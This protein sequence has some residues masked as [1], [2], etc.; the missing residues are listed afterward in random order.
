[1]DRYAIDP[2]LVTLPSDGDP[3]PERWLDALRGWLEAVSE[4]PEYCW[5]HFLPCTLN[6][7]EAKRYPDFLSLR[8]LIDRCDAELDAGWVSRHLSAFF[9]DPD[10]AITAQCSIKA[11]LSEREPAIVPSQFVARNEA[12]AAGLIDD[13]LVLGCECDWNRS[14]TAIVS[15]PFDQAVSKV[16]INASIAMTEPP[17]ACPSGASAAI[18]AEFPF[19]FTPDGLTSVLEPRRIFSIGARAIR[20]DILRRAGSRAQHELVIGAGFLASLWDSSIVSDATASVKLLR[21]GA[22]LA[23]GTAVTMGFD[24]RPVRVNASP[25]AEQ[26]VRSR[27]GAKGWRLTLAKH[28]AGWRLQYWHFTRGDGREVFELANVV[29]EK[30][31]GMPD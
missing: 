1:M 19:V 4:G 26:V 30:Q 22:E 6:L 9:Q 20:Q 18:A 16:T 23:A 11:A 8:A 25:D 21:A 29:I 5:A 2:I 12:V 17:D 14:H 31:V 28:G 24:I 10:R 7:I 15:L 27:D 13:L 3:Y